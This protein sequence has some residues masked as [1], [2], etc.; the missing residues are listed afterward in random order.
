[1]DGTCGPEMGRSFCF[2]G[3]VLFLRE[4]KRQDYIP[5]KKKM[6]KGRRRWNK[7]DQMEARPRCL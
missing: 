4:I 3:R 7:V 1:M 5:V 2:P 6:S